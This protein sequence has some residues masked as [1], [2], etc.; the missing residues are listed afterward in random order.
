M[1]PCQELKAKRQIRVKISYRSNM[2]QNKVLNHISTRLPNFF[3]VC[4]LKINISL[5]Q[6][7]TMDRGAW[8]KFQK[9]GM[10]EDSK[11]T[12]SAKAQKCKMSWEWGTNEYFC[13]PYVTIL[14]CPSWELPEDKGKNET[15]I[16]GLKRVIL[17]LKSWIP[18]SLNWAIIND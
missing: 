18:L 17:N 9:E 14:W 10:R 15:H 7:D 12:K 6:K 11:R 8:I 5:T 16:L 3:S 2:Y 1:I 4:E 13:L